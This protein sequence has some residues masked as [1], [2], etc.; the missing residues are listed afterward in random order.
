[1]YYILFIFLTY[2]E[3]FSWNHWFPI[4]SISC[5]DFSNPQSI[6][7]YGNEYM[8]TKIYSQYLI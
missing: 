7:L 4:V 5:T 3:A 6:E 1:M 8:N 2:T